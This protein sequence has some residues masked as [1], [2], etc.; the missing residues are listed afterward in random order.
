MMYT[1]IVNMEYTII[2]NKM[3]TITVNV[4]NMIMILIP[5]VTCKDSPEKLTFGRQSAKRQGISLIL[6]SDWLIVCKKKG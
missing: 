4:M 2:V 5:R 1:I 6:L 3:M